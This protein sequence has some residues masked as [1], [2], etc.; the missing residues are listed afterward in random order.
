MLFR[1]MR[2]SNKLD[3]HVPRGFLF[4]LN[5]SSTLHNKKAM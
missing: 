1:L 4:F 5:D 2:I 3:K